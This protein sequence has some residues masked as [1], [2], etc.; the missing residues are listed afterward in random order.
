MQL[1]MVNIALNNIVIFIFWSIFEFV[2]ELF[3]LISHSQM[4]SIVENHVVVV[5]M[6]LVGNT[7]VVWGQYHFGNF[8]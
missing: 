6:A 3:L 1:T 7:V 8:C 4:Q 5:S 2:I